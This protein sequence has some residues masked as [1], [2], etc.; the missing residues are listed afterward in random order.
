MNLTLAEPSKFRRDRYLDAIKVDP[1]VTPENFWNRIPGEIFVVMAAEIAT[2][3]MR[4]VEP[5]ATVE[6]APD[7]IAAL[8]DLIVRL[9]EARTI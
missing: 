4:Y 1:T 3:N 9:Q 7:V 5:R 6:T 8:R 2:I